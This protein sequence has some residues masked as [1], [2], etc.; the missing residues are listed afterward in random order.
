MSAYAVGLLK[1]VRFGAEIVEYLERIDA[2]LA[3]YCGRFL[4][5]GEP[6]EV[7]EGSLQHDV[8]VIAFPDIAVARAWYHSS[9]YQ[10]IL[11]LRTSNAISTVFL[12]DGLPEGHQA[13]DIF[14]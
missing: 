5:H 12:V 3:P 8:V 4:L 11:P 13:K 10:N 14:K 6:P 7:V 2:T 1:D 9:A